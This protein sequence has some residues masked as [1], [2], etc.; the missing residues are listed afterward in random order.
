MKTAII[1]RTAVYDYDA[2]NRLTKADYTA[3]VETQNPPPGE[4]TVYVE[5]TNL[6]TY[7]YDAVGNSINETYRSQNEILDA[8]KFQIEIDQKS[9]RRRSA[10]EFRKNVCVKSKSL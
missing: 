5:N 8:L 3:N 2:L 7:G 10:F 9:L 6:N 1:W 4:T